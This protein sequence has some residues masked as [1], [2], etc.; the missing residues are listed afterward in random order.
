MKVRV[1]FFGVLSEVAGT[2]MKFYDNVKSIEHLKMRVFDD[3]SEL[4]HYR[5][6][7]SLNN[8]LITGDA[9]LKDGDEAAMLPPFA[10]G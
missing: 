3:F 4:S 1:L 10:G 9:E 7:V 6:V 8:E 2:D 5:F